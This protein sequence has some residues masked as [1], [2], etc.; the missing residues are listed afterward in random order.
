M[1]LGKMMILVLRVGLTGTGD[2]E[3]H[4]GYDGD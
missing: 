2:Q 3:G 1:L 4:C